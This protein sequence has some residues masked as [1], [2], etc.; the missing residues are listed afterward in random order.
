M[1]ACTK[2]QTFLIWLKYQNRFIESRFG[3]IF[4]AKNE[5][6]EYSSQLHLP[7]FVLANFAVNSGK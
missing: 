3:G 2:P 1:R 4:Y 5:K 7:T 6:A